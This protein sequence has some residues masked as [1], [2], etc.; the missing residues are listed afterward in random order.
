MSWRLDRL[1]L[2]SASD[3]SERQNRHRH[4]YAHLQQPWQRLPEALPA[5]CPPHPGP[6]SRP[7]CRCRRRGCTA[8]RFPAHQRQANLTGRMTSST[9]RP[10]HCLVRESA[11]SFGIRILGITI[12]SADHTPAHESHTARL[13]PTPPHVTTHL[14]L[15]MPQQKVDLARRHALTVAAAAS[16]AWGR[17]P[18]CVRHLCCRQRCRR[19]VVLRRRHTTLQE[20]K[21][22]DVVYRL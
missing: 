6:P 22:Q 8:G 3:A 14:Q 2:E 1:A 4:V 9:H 20:Y 15:G 7:C 19:E 11:H 17:S 18:L 10:R 13:P 5:R 12:A 21:L 16:A